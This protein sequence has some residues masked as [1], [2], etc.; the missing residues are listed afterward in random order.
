MPNYEYEC[1]ACRQRFETWQSIV[2]RPLR[3]CARCGKKSARRL[4]GAGA[5][6]IFKGSGFYTTDYRKPSYKARAEADKKSSS[7]AKPS[8]SDGATNKKKS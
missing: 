3:K 7:P 8:G 2:A 1:S 4:I 6:L 5:G